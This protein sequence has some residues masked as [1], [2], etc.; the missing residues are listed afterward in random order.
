MSWQLISEAY[1]FVK[2]LIRNREAIFWLVVFPIVFLLILVTV[3]A[4]ETS[5]TYDVGLINRSQILNDI[6]ENIDFINVYYAPDNDSLYEMV[7]NGSI[8]VGI[9]PNLDVEF[10]VTGEITIVYIEDLSSSELAAQTLTSIISG[11]E[12]EVRSRFVNV[13]IDFVPEE[14]QG[15]LRLMYDPIKTD[16]ISITPEIYGT[17][18]G[19]KLFYVIS[20]IGAQI[21]YIGMFTGVLNLHEKR[22]NGVL[23]IIVSSPISS[24]KILMADVI[25]VIIG[26]LISSIAILLAGYFLGADYTALS[27]DTIGLIF[28]LAIIAQLFM[29]GLGL[30]LSAIPKTYEGASALANMLAFPL[31]FIGGIVI[32]DFLLPDYLKAFANV[33][34]VSRLVNT[35][36]EVLIFEIPLNNIIFDLIYGV[37]STVIVFAIGAFVYR[38]LLLRAIEH[39]I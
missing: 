35:M 23:K 13:S 17:P 39:P 37:I 3:F 18:G 31:L 28:G 25:S 5:V 36:R 12:D 22:K 32:P 20:M 7:R 30:V 10:G 33:F 38:R 16:F 26:I 24:F 2:G 11:I 21:I 14:F 8:D 27:I 4:S 29:V 6:L 34:P 19:L 1:V 15:F 9:I